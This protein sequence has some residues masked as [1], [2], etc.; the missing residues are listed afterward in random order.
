MNLLQQSWAKLD[1]EIKN[2]FSYSY[3]EKKLCDSLVVKITSGSSPEL[4]EFFKTGTVHSFSVEINKTNLNKWIFNCGR[5]NITLLF[6]MIKYKEINSHI[7][8]LHN[9][10]LEIKD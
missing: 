8:E 3:V 5:I 9:I 7:R 6:K 4:S 10:N 1:P 2:L